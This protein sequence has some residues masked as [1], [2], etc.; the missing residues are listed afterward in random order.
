MSSPDV[1]SKG[2]SKKLI[3]SGLD[4]ITSFPMYIGDK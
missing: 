4:K 3:R 1:G 2:S